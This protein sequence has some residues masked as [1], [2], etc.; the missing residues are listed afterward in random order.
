MSENQPVREARKLEL[1]TALAKLE[2]EQWKSWALTI[3]DTE[4]ISKARAARWLDLIN[5]GWDNLTEEEKFKDYEW[6]ERVLWEIHKHMGM[7]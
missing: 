2:H 7:R 3:L 1:L 6:A 5:S 4:E